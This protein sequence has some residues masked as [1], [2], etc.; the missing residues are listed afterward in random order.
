MISADSN[1]I[2]RSDAELVQIVDAAFADSAA[3]SGGHLA[4]RPGCTQCCHGA[5]AI[6]PLDA[7]R[8]RNAI[9]SLLLEN[10]AKAA[11]IE[12][13]ARAY[14]SEFGASFPGD[15]QTG[16]LDE[17]E[18]AQAA[19]DDFA[20][21]AACPALNPATG[22]CDVYDARP[23]TCRVFG[24]PVRMNNSPAEADEGEEGLAVCELCF[25]TAS[26]AEIAAAEMHVPIR[27]E[28]QLLEVL[29]QQ[30]GIQPRDTIVAYCLL[31]SAPTASSAP[32]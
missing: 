11:E 2:R 26:P 8:L 16:L 13:R 18:E 12:T 15:R 19:F 9:A 17:S 6:N 10:P 14:I 30:T 7:A 29:E 22:L 1:S 25:T 20:N 3:R 4:C 32:R 23:M 28:E 24:P 31:P 27:E 21:E 5:F